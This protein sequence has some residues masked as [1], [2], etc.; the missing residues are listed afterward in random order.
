MSEGKFQGDPAQPHSVFGMTRYFIKEDTA[1]AE[2]YSKYFFSNNKMNMGQV[3]L[4]TILKER[5][6]KM[7]FPCWVTVEFVSG[8]GG[9]KYFLFKHFDLS[10]AESNLV[11]AQVT[12]NQAAVL[13]DEY[14]IYIF[15]YFVCL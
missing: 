3:H 13:P 6:S 14:Y 7:Q 10:D 1:V 11:W 15:I 12:L 5:V 8:K 9:K 2:V 4:P